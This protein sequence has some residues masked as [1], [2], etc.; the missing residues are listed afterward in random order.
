MEHIKKENYK[1]R[2]DFCLFCEKD[3]S[4]FARHL[5]SWHKSESEVVQIFS[6]EAG[7]K[8][9]RIGI[10][11]LKKRG[12]FIRNTKD[13]TLRP[14][15]RVKHAHH[16][17][18]TDFLPCSHCLGFYKKTVL[19]RHTKI[20]SERP[21]DERTRQTSQSNGEATLLMSG[22][23]NTDKNLQKLFARMRID[24][25]TRTAENDFLICLYGSTYLIRRKAKLSFT[26]ARHDIRCISKLVRYCRKQHS[27][28]KQL[29]DLLQQKN[30]ELI[31]AAVNKLAR[32]DKNT[33]TFQSPRLA[34]NFGKLIRKCCDLAI[35]HLLQRKE[36]TDEQRK[37]LKNLKLLVESHWLNQVPLQVMPNTCEKNCSK[38]ESYLPTSDNSTDCE[39]LSKNTPSTSKQ[40]TTSGTPVST[41]LTNKR[42]TR[43][44]HQ[45]WTVEQKK[46]IAEF[47]ADNIKRKIAP[48]RYAINE[49]VILHPI[50][51]KDRKWTS[52]KAVVYNMYTGKLKVPL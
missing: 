45:T 27:D 47:F 6:H 12:N 9:R 18:S 51:F 48:K 37:D 35:I 20:C 52:I 11:R 38:N 41:I 33:E 50:L 49:L 16:V 23:Y 32:Y 19:Y 15:K 10:L 13:S 29:I 8:Q 40:C 3:V 39:A 43:S 14:V 2:K 24:N 1:D 46:V 28:I 36:N 21:K 42:K 44:V 26:T 31:V 5:N 7:S 4:H 22:F 30:F 34:L 25:V 17:E